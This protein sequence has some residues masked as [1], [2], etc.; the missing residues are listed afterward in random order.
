MKRL[1]IPTHSAQDILA[2]CIDSIRDAELTHRLRQ[3]LGHIN[4]AESTYFT[5]GPRYEL[6]TILPTEGIATYVTTKEM[7]R[8][9]KDTFVRSVNTRHIY[10]ALKSAPI[11]DICPLC[12]QRTV[13][14]LDH[15]L[16]KSA[17]PSLAITPI[18]LVPSCIECNKTKLA[19]Q[20]EDAE[21]QT[22]HPYFEDADEGR[23]LYAEVKETSPAALVFFPAPPDNWPTL[24]QQRIVNHFN[25]Y[26]LAALYASHSAVE[27]NN[28]RHNLI[29]RAQCSPP[30]AIQRYLTDQATSCAAANANSWHTAAYEALANSEW[31]YSGGFA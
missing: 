30:E 26:K 13:S 15:Y 20:A 6:H 28:I 4:L 21:G 16:P 14:T 27:L 3:T 19:L 8:V 29:K 22:F 25:T 18:N 2:L 24:K 12:S 9:Y 23:W 10:G 5:R 1:P 11:N 7:E 17:H 31:F